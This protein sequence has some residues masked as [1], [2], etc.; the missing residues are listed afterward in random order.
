MVKM[1]VKKVVW[2]EKHIIEIFEYRYISLLSTCVKNDESQIQH[3][4]YY[5]DDVNKV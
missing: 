5:N 4:L 3:C 2:Y 1:K